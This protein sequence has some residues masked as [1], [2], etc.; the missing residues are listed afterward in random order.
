MIEVAHFGVLSPEEIRTYSTCEVTS[1]DCFKGDLPVPG[2]PC[3]LRLGAF[4]HFPCAECGK[5]HQCPG[6]PGHIDLVEPVYNV[7]LFAQTKYLLSCICLKCARV[8]VGPDDPMREPGARVNVDRVRK[9]VK[10]RRVCPHCRYSNPVVKAK[11]PYLEIAHPTGRTELFPS[12]A[13]FELLSRISIEETLFL[14]LEYDPC[15]LLYSAFPVLDNPSRPNSINGHQISVDKLSLRIGAIVNANKALAKLEKKRDGEYIV[16]LHMLQDQVNEFFTSA[17]V[18]QSVTFKKQSSRG[19]GKGASGGADE[20]VPL[21][22]RLKSKEGQLRNNMMGKRV[23][24]CARTVITGDPTLDLDQI[25][26]PKYIA[27]TM[28]Y[29]EFVNDLNIRRVAQRRAL[30]KFLHR[31]DADGKARTFDFR[32]RSGGPPPE[33]EIVVGDRIERPLMDD[34]LVVINRQPTLHRQSMMAVR[35]KIRADPGRGIALNVN[36]TKPLNAD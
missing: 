13:V 28:T 34:D 27:D 17:Y 35:A 31:V 25:A 9:E 22:N 15:W 23:N 16:A 21:H 4:A 36:L 32:S 10:N 3:D 11:G 8:K 33:F 1:A 24:Y 26:V 12:Y 2:G 29:Q 18:T 30:I 20:G 7:N 5:K 19:A 6:H 14:R